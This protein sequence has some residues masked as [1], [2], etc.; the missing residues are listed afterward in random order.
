MRQSRFRGTEGSNPS[1]SSGESAANR[2][3]GRRHLIL[4]RRPRCDE[5]VGPE[6]RAASRVGARFSRSPLGGQS[7]SRATRQALDDSSRGN[8]AHYRRVHIDDE[9]LVTDEL[10]VSPAAWRSRWAKPLQPVGVTR[11]TAEA[12][13]FEAEAPSTYAIRNRRGTSRR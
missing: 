3:S 5:A 10:V 4:G 8:I 1:P 6:M 7:G 13:G 12:W 9:S 2:G 11:A